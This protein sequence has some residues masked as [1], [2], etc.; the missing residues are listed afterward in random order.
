MVRAELAVQSPP[1]E[2]QHEWK[3]AGQKNREQR[4]VRGW[5]RHATRV[6]QDEVQK[7]ARGRENRDQTILTRPRRR[8]RPPGFRD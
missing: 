8:R 3:S 6:A 4:Q 7:D 1:A 2:A 5:T